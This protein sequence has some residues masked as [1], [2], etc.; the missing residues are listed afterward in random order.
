MISS[1]SSRMVA[2]MDLAT[3]CPGLTI[4]SLPLILPAGGAAPVPLL[5]AG[6]SSAGLPRQEF[7]RLDAETDRGRH[8]DDG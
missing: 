1:F 2:P 7:R 5:G 6:G 4:T 8:E 3:D